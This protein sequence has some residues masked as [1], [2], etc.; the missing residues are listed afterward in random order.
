MSESLKVVFDTQI[1]LRSIINRNSISGKL[2]AIWFNEYELYVADEIENEINDVL[3]R[4]KLRKKFAQ[5]SDNDIEKVLE[6][7]ARTYRVELPDP[8]EAVSRDP[9]DDKFLA[10]AK[11]ATADYLVT[12][13]NDL[14]VLT[15]YEG[16][17][18]INAF[19]FLRILESRK[20]E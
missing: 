14:L 17:K 20:S 10:C 9:K 11:T 8:V 12:E 2:F 7:V 4:P 16:T 18:I 6:I 19:D 3:N 13:D 1:F 15:E 5:I